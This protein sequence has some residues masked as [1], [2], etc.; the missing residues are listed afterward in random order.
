MIMNEIAQKKVY[1]RKERK[2]FWTKGKARRETSAALIIIISAS[3]KS[4]LPMSFFC[5]P[6]LEKSMLLPK[7]AQILPGMY[8]LISEV[9]HMKQVSWKRSE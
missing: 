5:T 9:N 7:N 3:S 1:G 6:C 8:R 4:D 2:Y